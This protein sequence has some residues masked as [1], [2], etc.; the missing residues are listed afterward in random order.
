MAITI[1]DMVNITSGKHDGDY[2]LITGIKSPGWYIL[3]V[4]S[5]KYGECSHIYPENILTL[6]DAL[7]AAKPAEPHYQTLADIV[8]SGKS[9][10]DGFNDESVRVFPMSKTDARKEYRKAYSLGQR[11]SKYIHD[12]LPIVR[13]GKRVHL[14]A[15]DMETIGK[16][17]DSYKNV[18]VAWGLSRSTARRDHVFEYL[19]E[20]N[21]IQPG[22]YVVDT[23]FAGSIPKRISEVLDAEIKCVLLSGEATSYGRR[24]S[25]DADV[26]SDVL[27][28][29]HAAKYTVNAGDHNTTV[30]IVDKTVRTNAAIWR[31][32]F[33][34]GAM[35]FPLPKRFARIEKFREESAKRREQ[36]Y[37]TGNMLRELDKRARYSGQ[38]VLEHTR[39]G[40]GQYEW[41]VK[42]RTESYVPSWY[43]H[44]LVYS[45]K[46]R[47]ERAARAL[48]ERQRLQPIMNRLTTRELFP[49]GIGPTAFV[50]YSRTHMYSDL[51]NDKHLTIYGRWD[52]ATIMRS[53]SPSLA[54]KVTGLA[55]D[56]E[57]RS[58]Y[59]DKYYH[60]IFVC[61]ADTYSPEYQTEWYA[62]EIERNE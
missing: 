5:A 24:I 28:F 39:I 45:S 59:E 27:S 8:K 31:M 43:G 30:S 35:G 46:A 62:M 61:F 15:R 13:S 19:V 52:V 10:P 41:T 37:Q 49:Y 16:I 36:Y 34:A 48:N 44:Q 56:A 3:T 51:R 4:Y 57:Y 58:G 33:L 1:G 50:D 38:W 23:G 55:Y 12:L 32:G 42:P 20:A 26:R 25:E 18:S 40:F 22:D 21:G 29:E 14:L 9:L 54:D 11:L 53:I 60:R 17:F 7:D 2:G 47:A 6:K